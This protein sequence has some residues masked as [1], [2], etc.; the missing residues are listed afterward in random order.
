[1]ATSWHPLV[2]EGAPGRGGGD[3]LRMA[4][5]IEGYPGG[6][7]GGR[8]GHGDCLHTAYL[9]AGGWAGAGQRAW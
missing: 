1:M 8:G 4:C 9:H 3:L 7:G 2:E 5:M 6:G